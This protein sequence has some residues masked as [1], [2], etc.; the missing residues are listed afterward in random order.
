VWLIG[1]KDTFRFE[2]P[3]TESD[4]TWFAGLHV[5]DRI[6]KPVLDYKTRKRPSKGK[7]LNNRICIQY[8]DLFCTSIVEC[9]LSLNAIALVS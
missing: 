1:L 5:A 6:A 8:C 2:I 7:L 9:K 3:G 4:M